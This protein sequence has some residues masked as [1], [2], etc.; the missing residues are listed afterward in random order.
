MKSKTLPTPAQIEEQAAPL[1]R[2]GLKTHCP[3]GHEYTPENTK[4][5]KGRRYCRTCLRAVEKRRYE[6]SKDGAPAT[7]RVK[8][9]VVELEQHTTLPESVL[10]R[11]MGV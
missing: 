4:V 8:K 5:A 3:Q 11:L 1:L 2:N 7:V 10:A 6:R 9:M